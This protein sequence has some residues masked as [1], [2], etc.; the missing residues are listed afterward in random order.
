MVPGSSVSLEVV[1]E[2]PSSGDEKDNK[3]RTTEGDHG[4]I[5]DVPTDAHE[6]RCH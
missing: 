5:L 1:W 2:R 6:M 4:A 3:C